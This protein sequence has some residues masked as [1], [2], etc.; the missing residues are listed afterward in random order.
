VG[1]YRRVCTR[2]LKDLKAGG[3]TADARLAASFGP[4]HDLVRLC[5]LRPDAVGDWQPLGQLAEHVLAALKTTEA[6]A[7]RRQQE[8]FRRAWLG[9]R[10]AVLCRAGHYR[11]AIDLL[12]ESVGAD[13]T[14]GTFTAWVFLALAHQGL[15]QA[16]EAR[17]W[18]DKALAAPPAAGAPFS[19][20]ALEV[21]LLR[22]E[23]SAVR[24]PAWKR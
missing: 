24:S 16:A 9:A 20:G 1:A 4:L 5:V 2:L 13:G 22:P 3:P 14:G 17:R 15:G 18:I 19:W 23:A 21:D 6:P 10:G 11:K 7:D 12:R 8:E